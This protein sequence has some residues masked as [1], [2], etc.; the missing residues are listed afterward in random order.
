MGSRC[1]VLHWQLVTYTPT[2]GKPAAAATD[3]NRGRTAR[4]L[5]RHY[6]TSADKLLVRITDVHMTA[7]VHI[8]DRYVSLHHL[9]R[10]HTDTFCWSEKI[11]VNIY[12]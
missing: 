3:R 6:I 11:L 10:Y 1:S 2:I 9:Y 8:T 4:K 7:Q 12:Q 5:F